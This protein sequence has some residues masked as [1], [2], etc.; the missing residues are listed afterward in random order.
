MKELNVY[1]IEEHHEA[2]FIWKYALSLGLINPKNN[3]LLHFD[4]HSD[5]ATP[6][7]N[8]PL[9]HLNGDLTDIL[10][11]TY[12][13]LNIANFIIPALHESLF[14][15]VYWI[16]QFHPKPNAEGHKMYVR[17][18]NGQG[19]RL[20]TK[21]ESLLEGFKDDIPDLLNTISRYRY[22]KCH[23]DDLTSINDVCLDIDLD[24]F[25]CNQDPLKKE[26]RIEISKSEY[27]EFIKNPYHRMNFYEFG[28][29]DACE[30]NGKYFFVLNG[31]VYKFKSPI[32]VE[33]EEILKRIDAVADVL[34]SKDIQPQIITICRSRFSGYTP[35][36]Q[37]QF[38]EEHLLEKIGQL[39][40]IKVQQLSELLKEPLVN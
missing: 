35:D 21:E 3:V 6:T 25:S 19:E 33:E 24:Y 34:K 37:W 36:D 22:Y 15:K 29:V 28:R 4:E 16:K 20:I 2:Y 1:I 7:L 14:D 17:S 11:W 10:D 31:Y 32:K 38:I 40:N 39:Y 5:M 26:L 18:H 12:K 27:E 9:K 23:V 30:E 13:E 8:I